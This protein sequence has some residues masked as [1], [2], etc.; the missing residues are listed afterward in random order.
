[1]PSFTI[2]YIKDHRLNQSALSFSNLDFSEYIVNKIEENTYRLFVK[3]NSYTD[4]SEKIIPK[5]VPLD[6]MSVLEVLRTI[7]MIECIKLGKINFN[8]DYCTGRIE[9]DFFQKNPCSTIYNSHIDGLHEEMNKY[10]AFSEND[11]KK[12]TNIRLIRLLNYVQTK[13]FLISTELDFIEFSVLL[14]ELFNRKNNFDK[15]Y[16]NFS[17]NSHNKHII[18]KS[19]RK[20]FLFD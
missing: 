5:I 16:T 1:M 10:L 20:V 13:D 14:N 8:K 7:P 12:T 15:N 11:I 6:S 9:K 2:F 18:K 4:L 3:T 19:N 17:I